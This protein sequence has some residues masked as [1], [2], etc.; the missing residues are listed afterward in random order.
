MRN[1]YLF[2]VLVTCAL[3]L[4]ALP[5]AHAA[6]PTPWHVYIMIDVPGLGARVIQ[7]KHSFATADACGEALLA[8]APRRDEDAVLHSS[9]GPVQILA[10]ACLADGSLA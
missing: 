7:G 9:E 3:L 10:M 2:V 1:A 8:M 5:K 4:L 6:P